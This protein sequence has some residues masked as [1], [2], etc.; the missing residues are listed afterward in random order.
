MSP[1]RVVRRV[2][3]VAWL[4]L[5]DPS[6]APRTFRGDDTYR[7][8][9]ELNGLNE[10][11]EATA[12]YVLLD[13]SAEMYERCAPE[14]WRFVRTLFTL[15][16]LLLSLLLSPYFFFNFNFKQAYG[17]KICFQG[18][19]QR[20]FFLLADCVLFWACLGS[21]GPQW[22]V[23]KTPQCCVA[24]VG[25][26]HHLNCRPLPFFS[27]LFYIN[28]GDTVTKAREWREIGGLWRL[29]F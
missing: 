23:C 15:C 14:V 13:G 28:R 19:D 18:A 25:E 6:A 26:Q 21:N 2:V 1:R 17:T 7:K 29:W 11:G 22:R 5:L 4:Y 8:C 10:K 24:T 27:F 3:K 16:S 20:V 9:Q 12:K